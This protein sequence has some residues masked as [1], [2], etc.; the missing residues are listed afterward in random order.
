[1]LE[2]IGSLVPAIAVVHLGDGRPPAAGEQNRSPLGSGEVPL[3]ELV[4]ALSAAG[5]DGDYDVELLGEEIE[6]AD[7]EQLLRQSKEAGDRLIGRS[8]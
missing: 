8:V 6:A 2:R 5:Y 7:Y 4:A 1:M 3:R